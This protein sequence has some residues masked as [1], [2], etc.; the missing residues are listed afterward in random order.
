[1]NNSRV[2]RAGFDFKKFI[3]I[4]DIRS[5]VEIEIK[6]VSLK[7]QMG[8]KRASLN[9]LK[10]TS[11]LLESLDDPNLKL[12]LIIAYAKYYSSIGNTDK[13]EESI[14]QARILVKENSTALMN[15]KLLYSI[16]TISFKTGLM[17]NSLESN[18][19]KLETLL[20]QLKD[21]KKMI[22]GLN[23]IGCA[24]IRLN[25]HEETFFDYAT[26]RTTISGHCTCR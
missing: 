21:N 5:Q 15:Y 24:E 2:K 17:T 6:L 11:L 1:M 7:L 26:G 13:T 23:A 8:K 19:N 9:S 3:E 22:N 4:G 12:D 10:K 16:L 14:E 18:K 25:R 20:P